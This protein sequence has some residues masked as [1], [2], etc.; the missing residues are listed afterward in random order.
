VAYKIT[1]AL[2][3]PATVFPI[4]KVVILLPIVGVIGP[5]QWFML[6][7]ID[8][9]ILLKTSMPSPHGASVWLG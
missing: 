3:T 9:H 8:F 1:I 7:L 6:D 4:L 5:I 2:D